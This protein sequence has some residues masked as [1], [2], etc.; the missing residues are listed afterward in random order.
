MKELEDNF[1]FILA[2]LNEKNKFHLSLYFWTIYREKILKC[3]RE[4]SSRG[5]TSEAWPLIFSQNSKGSGMARSNEDVRKDLIEAIEFEKK[6]ESSK[7]NE[8]LQRLLK[9]IMGCAV[10]IKSGSEELIIEPYW[11][12]L[13]FNLDGLSDPFCYRSSLKE[14]CHALYFK[15]PC[16]NKGI[17]NGRNR[18][19]I[20]LGTKGKE[21]SFLLKRAILKDKDGNELPKGNVKGRSGRRFWSDAYIAH[22][23]LEKF[24]DNS[25]EYEFIDGPS[26]GK[27]EFSQ[28]IRLNAESK[29]EKSWLNKEYAAYD[30][31]EFARSEKTGGIVLGGRKANKR[32]T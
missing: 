5:F 18:M 25:I 13:Y 3:V 20:C 21:I 16:Q 26:H 1:R 24:G 8:N 27:I 9:E 2:E 28:R 31:N 14:G 4:W 29:E 11:G 19:D 15:S 22:L 10:K 6:N 7:P 23:I 32:A 30:S 12:E 17:F